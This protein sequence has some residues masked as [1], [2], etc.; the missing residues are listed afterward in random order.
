MQM[1]YDLEIFC[2]KCVIVYGQHKGNTKK[3]LVQGIQ[4]DS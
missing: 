1:P 2:E 4:K 3:N